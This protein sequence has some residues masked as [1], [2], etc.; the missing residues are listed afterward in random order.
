MQTCGY[1]GSEVE[2]K[3][4]MAYCSFC[5]LD[6]WEDDITQDGQRRALQVETSVLLVDA[7]RSTGY[8]L[9]QSTFSLIKLLKLVRAE[10]KRL[11]ELSRLF[12]KGNEAG[13]GFTD[14]QKVINEDYELFSRKAWVIE[15]ILRDKMTVF[16]PRITDDMLVKMLEQLEKQS[17]DR[18]EFRLPRAGVDSGSN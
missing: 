14:Q 5:E 1:C 4:H 13:G 3:Q 17:A 7:K 15:N 6:L 10:R 12:R 2:V 16:P 18:M 11:Y 8:L 9:E